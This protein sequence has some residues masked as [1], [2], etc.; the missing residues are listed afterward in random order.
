MVMYEFEFSQLSFS[1]VIVES[2]R[3]RQTFP[4]EPKR[5]CYIDRTSLPWIVGVGGSVELKEQRDCCLEVLAM[6]ETES[7][8]MEEEEEENPS[9]PTA[10]ATA[11]AAM[12]GEQQSYSWPVIQFNSPPQ[13]T[14]HFYNQFR[15]G[16]NPNNFFKGVKW[17]IAC[18]FLFS[19]QFTLLLY[20]SFFRNLGVITCYR[21]PDGSCFLTS[22]EDNSLRIFNL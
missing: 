10:E 15:T 18:V 13:R 20:S 16:P 11:E 4:K 17:Y 22:S 3:R 14:Y 5:F 9:N 8:I 7:M 12:N 19:F 1:R 2:R 21:S 6:S